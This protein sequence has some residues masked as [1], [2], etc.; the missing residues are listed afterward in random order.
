MEISEFCI[1]DVCSVANIWHEIVVELG[2]EEHQ[3]AVDHS[4]VPR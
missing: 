3:V 1:G 2:H 4:S